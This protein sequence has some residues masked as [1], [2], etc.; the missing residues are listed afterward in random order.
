MLLI[1]TVFVRRVHGGLLVVVSRV[2]AFGAWRCRCL[3][4]WCLLVAFRIKSSMLPLAGLHPLL[5]RHPFSHC[6]ATAMWHRVVLHFFAPARQLQH[7][8]HPWS[9]PV[10][11]EG[12]RCAPQVWFLSR[13]PP[14]MQWVRPRCL[15]AC[16]LI[17]RAKGQWR[18]V[19]A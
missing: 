14:R 10:D 17:A 8:L 19:G 4:S 15:D 11:G 18:G 2:V 5:L 6:V 13:T 3:C 12:Q 16:T 9:S 7:P 1:E